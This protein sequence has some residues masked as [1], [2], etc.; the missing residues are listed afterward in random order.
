MKRRVSNSSNARRMA[1]HITTKYVITTMFDD[2]LHISC[3]VFAFCLVSL[4]GD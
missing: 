3:F 2:V 4:H 1:T